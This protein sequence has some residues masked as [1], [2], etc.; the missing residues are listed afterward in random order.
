MKRQNNGSWLKITGEVRERA[1]AERKAKRE[2]AERMK[3]T[4]TLI[5][6]HD[7]DRWRDELRQALNMIGEARLIFDSAYD[8]IRTLDAEAQD[9]YNQS[10]VTALEKRKADSDGTSTEAA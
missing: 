4:P 10:L 6:A 8:I 5:S 3:A 2:H 1:E 9:F 7:I